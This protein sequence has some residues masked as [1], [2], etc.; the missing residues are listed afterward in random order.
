MRRALELEIKVD[1]LLASLGLLTNEKDHSPGQLGEF[2][3]LHFDTVRAV[4]YLTKDKAAS[5][6]AKLAQLIKKPGITPRE[7][8]KVRGVLI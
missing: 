6:V 7:L 3:G 5:L 1:Q 4:F 2:C 8:A